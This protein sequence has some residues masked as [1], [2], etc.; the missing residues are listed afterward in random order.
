MHND[1]GLKPAQSVA[2]FGVG[3]IG[4]ATVAMA[5]LLSANP[6]IAIDVNPLKLKKAQELGATHLINSGKDD[7]AGKLLDIAPGGVDAAIETTGIRSVRE[8]AYELTHREGITT[9]VGVPKHGEKMSI[10][11]FQLH[12]GKRITG[13]H[14]GNVNPSAIIPKLIELDM[15]KGLGLGKMV[16]KSY[17]LK[18]INDAISDMRA[19]KVLRPII[20]M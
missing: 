1:S 10:D 13:S 5:R 3:G 19:G 18:E 12:F 8:S 15:A 20:E 11:S 7:V 9:L 14:G 6:I 16:S 2:I 17:K 4:T